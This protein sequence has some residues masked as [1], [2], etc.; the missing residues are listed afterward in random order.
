MVKFLYSVILASFSLSSFAAIDIICRN[1]RGDSVQAQI[2]ITGEA[3]TNGTW[4]YVSAHADVAFNVLGSTGII[5]KNT[6]MIFTKVGWDLD[7][8]KIYHG[9]SK[10]VQFSKKH[11]NIWARYVDHQ[12]DLKLKCQEISI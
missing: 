10:M 2:T 9:Y 12:K 6:V 3:D 4:N 11:T 1:S 7:V 8:Y 5:Q